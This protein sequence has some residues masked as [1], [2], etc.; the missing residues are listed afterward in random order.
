MA[1]CR[2]RQIDVLTG[3]VEI[4]S[5]DIVYDSGTSLSPLVDIGQIEGA[6]VMGMGLFLTEKL[7]FDPTSG[8]LQSL[9]TFEYKPP[10]ALDIPQKMTVSG[11]HDRWMCVYAPRRAV[12]CC[13]VPCRAV[14]C[15][16]AMSRCDASFR[17]RCCRTAPIPWV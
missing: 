7:A 11:V 5:T 6:F 14:P 3:E 12:P 15:R 13:A 17:R 10:Q 2:A 16:A 1:A 8:A 4:L 9:G